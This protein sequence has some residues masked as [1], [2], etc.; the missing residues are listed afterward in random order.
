VVE[1]AASLLPEVRNAAAEA[2]QEA[3]VTRALADVALLAEE[4][5][6]APYTIYIRLRATCETPTRQPYASPLNCTNRP[7]RAPR[8]ANMCACIY[9]ASKHVVIMLFTRLCLDRRRSRNSWRLRQHRVQFGVEM[10]SKRQRC[11]RRALQLRAP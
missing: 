11:M 7:R 2:Q 1:D 6:T 8:A 10:L 4:E 5:V 9:S 3:E